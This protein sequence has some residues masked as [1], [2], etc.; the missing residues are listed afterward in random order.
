[1]SYPFIIKNVLSD[2]TFFT[3][4]DQFK[5][6]WKLTNVSNPEEL[7]SKYNTNQRLAWTLVSPNDLIIFECASIIKLK[8]QKHLKRNVKFIRSHVNGHTFGQCGNFHIDYHQDYVWTFIFFCS[9]VW[10]INWGGEF[11]CFDPLNN[12]YKYVPYIPNT[13]CLIPANW[14][15]FG[16]SPNEKT[17]RLRV[18]I[19]FSF[20]LAE[21]FDSFKNYKSVLR[22]S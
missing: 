2:K 21:K 16:S 22:F 20:C 4:N 15:H 3:L 12:E 9:P 6:G 18:S 17:D 13:G 7:N 8:I 14:Q 10:D 5:L 1:M 19:G 11:V